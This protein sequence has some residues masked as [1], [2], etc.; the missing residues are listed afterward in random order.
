MP[1]L[2]ANTIT[3]IPEFLAAVEG[4]RALGHALDD[5]EH[6]EDG[7]CVAVAITGSGVPAAISVSAPAVRFAL[8][9][10]GPVADALVAAASE[11][12]V[13]EPAAA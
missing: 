9:E 6:E 5:R 8:S 11:I 3:R 7:R 10:V 13:T 1:R 2:T 12:G 4:V